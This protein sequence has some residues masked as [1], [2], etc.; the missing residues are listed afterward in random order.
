[1]ITIKKIQF[2][3][4]GLKIKF[5]I[6]HF[7]PDMQ[8]EIEMISADMRGTD[9]FYFALEKVR[10]GVDK[11]AF[12]PNE[13]ALRRRQ[14]TAEKEDESYLQMSFDTLMFGTDETGQFAQ[15]TMAAGLRHF[16]ETGSLK[17]PK[18]YYGVDKKIMSLFPPEEHEDIAVMVNEAESMVAQ[19]L[20]RIGELAYRHMDERL[21]DF[22]IM[23]GDAVVSNMSTIR[24]QIVKLGNDG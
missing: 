14:K 1:M 6:L 5:Q 19:Y 11:I 2:T 8:A 15:F 22:E 17:L 18:A 23:A 20:S 7:E 21:P 13:A 4:K 9:R 24:P 16:S 10:G 12:G 3:E